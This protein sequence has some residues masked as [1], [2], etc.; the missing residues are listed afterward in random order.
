MAADQPGVKDDKIQNGI[1]A[2]GIA[3]VDL[4]GIADYKVALPRGE[5]MVCNLHPDRAAFDR[6][7][8]DLAVPVGYKADIFV[9]AVPDHE[10]GGIISYF[11]ESF[12]GKT[13]E[14]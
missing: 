4:T 7:Q 8:F 5:G 2:V 13:V 1:L 10:V 12:H 14:L 11:M 3:V 9:C 6:D